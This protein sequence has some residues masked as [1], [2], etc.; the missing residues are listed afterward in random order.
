MSGIKPNMVT[1]R[2][3]LLCLRA[4]APHGQSLLQKCEG[5][6]SGE[7]TLPLGR[8]HLN[9]LCVRMHK[10]RTDWDKDACGMM[11]SQF[12]DT[13]AADEMGMDTAEEYTMGALLTGDT[14]GAPPSR[15]TVEALLLENTAEAHYQ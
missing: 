6:S 10:K 12:E 11:G 14:V 7:R 13:T 15:D 4:K 3:V 8:R 2:V 9:T 5:R 1:G